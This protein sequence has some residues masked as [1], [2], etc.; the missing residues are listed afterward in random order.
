M[1]NLDLDLYLSEAIEL[2]RKLWQN[3]DT[4]VGAACL[5]IPSTMEAIYDV[6]RDVG[7][8]HFA[9]AEHNVINAY[10][11]KHKAPPPED[12]ILITTI[13]P[14]SNANSAWRV[15]DSCSTLIKDFGIKH[16]YAGICVDPDASHHFELEVT[17][18]VALAETCKNL[19][20]LFNIK[21][22]RQKDGSP[23]R[24]VNAYKNKAVFQRVFKSQP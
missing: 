2:Q 17:Q 24:L 6:C 20:G 15:G 8:N 12:A 14:C 7:H 11:K 16:V 18:N 22:G 10:I 9:H 3:K 23:A 19:H 5:L 13:S 4:G 21:A 1:K